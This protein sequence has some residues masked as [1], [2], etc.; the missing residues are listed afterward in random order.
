MDKYFNMN[1]NDK[2]LNYRYKIPYFKVNIAGKG[3]GIHTIFLN[4]N[5]IS[6]SINHPE[7]ILLKYIA[8]STGSNYISNKT[9]ITGTHTTEDLKNLILI[10]IKNLVMCPKC[11]IP[12]TIPILII[13]NKKNQDV[14]LSCLACRNETLLLN[15]NNNIN[16]SINLIK[17]YLIKSEG[18]WMNNIYVNKTETILLKYDSSDDEEINFD[19][20]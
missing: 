19:D 2:D 7:D 6:K 16:K 12:E 1:G 3:N 10:Y 18:K 14:K 20:I 17:N 4:I 15:K 8:S 11:N 5:N 13:H 9:A